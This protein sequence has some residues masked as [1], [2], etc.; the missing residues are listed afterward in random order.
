MA[1]LT[2]RAVLRNSHS[3]MFHW[4][5]VRWNPENTPEEYAAK[6]AVLKLLNAVLVV[7]GDKIEIELIGD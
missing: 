1:K 6:G 3:Q 7:P 2:M 4:E 5:D